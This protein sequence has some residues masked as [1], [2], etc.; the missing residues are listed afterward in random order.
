M[1]LPNP[2]QKLF[3]LGTFYLNEKDIINRNLINLDSFDSA[4]INLIVESNGTLDLENLMIESF[5]KYNFY[6]SSLETESKFLIDAINLELFEGTDENLY[7][8]FKA[9]IPDYFRNF[10]VQKDYI[11]KIFF[12]HVNLI[13]RRLHLLNGVTFPYLKIVVEEGQ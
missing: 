12:L 3:F 11:I 9:N 2:S 8:K 10:L 7:G 5:N 1:F 4:K 13:D 6:E